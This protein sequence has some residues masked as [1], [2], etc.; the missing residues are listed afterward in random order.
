MNGTFNLLEAV[1]S[2][3]TGLSEP[4]RGKFRFLQVSTDEVYGTLAV[5]IRRLQSAR[6]THRIALI[7]RLKRP[8]ITWCAPTITPIICQ[9]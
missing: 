9:P 7:P 2:Y 3:W 6:R 5:P 8:P 4:D 1:R